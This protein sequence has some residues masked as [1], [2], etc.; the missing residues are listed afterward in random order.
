M[1]INDLHNMNSTIE[2]SLMGMAG[3]DPLA[4]ITQMGKELEDLIRVELKNY[5]NSYTP[6]VYTRT[7][8]S[9]SDIKVR[10]VARTGLG[11]ELIIDLNSNHRSL[12]GGEDANS[13]WL[14]NAGYVAKGLEDKLGKEVEHFTRFKGTNFINKAIEKFNKSNNMDVQISLTYNG[15]DVTGREFSYGK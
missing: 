5:Y 12:F 13:L 1:N 3:I 11:Y 4:M 6:T 15:Q 8:T 2:K 7:N 10:T 9:V 14:L